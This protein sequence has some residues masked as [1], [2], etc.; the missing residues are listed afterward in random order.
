[1]SQTLGQ[2]IDLTRLVSRLGRGP[3]TG[4]DR[5]ETAY[6]RQ[7]LSQ[8]DL[9]F[10]LVRT[11]FGYLLLDRRG[12]V[13]LEAALDGKIN[14]PKP[15]PILRRL[16]RGP[17]RH[18]GEALARGIAISR[19][20]GILLPYLLRKLPL[21]LTY[22]N[23]GHANLTNQ[24]LAALSGAQIKMVVLIHDTIPLD[25]PQFCRSDKITPFAAKIAATSQYA[26]WVVHV[27]ADARA[28]TERHLAAFGR[29]PV[30]ITAHLGVEVVK[31]HPVHQSTPYFVALG[32]I[33]PRKNHAFL[34]DI[35]DDLARDGHG[36]QLYIVGAKGWSSDDV[37][38]KMQ[39][40]IDKG[41]VVHHSD[42]QDADVMGLLQGARALLFPSF[43]EGFGLPPV[44][45]ASLGVPVLA[46]DLP[47]IREVLGDF[48]VYL[49]VEDWYSWRQKIGDLTQSGPRP[50]SKTNFIP[51]TWSQ[52]F[53]IIFTAIY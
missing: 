35:W 26:D 33:E 49:D 1:M 48:A 45:A 6:L 2:L 5:V 50:E 22:W 11:R 12:C 27:S 29:I 19:C 18:R 21:G 10:G 15:G 16:L 3:Q 4:I 25:H 34:L 17:W 42:M 44:E 28:K 8:D 20:P 41:L 37:F 7:F 14:L 40:L 38:A 32:T 52:H 39:S 51:R 46:N 13:T 43:A 9:L 36:P 23:L 47:V 53:N 24:T 31:G 30:G